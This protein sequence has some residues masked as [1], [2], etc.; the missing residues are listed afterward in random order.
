[1]DLVVQLVLSHGIHAHHA[2]GQVDRGPGRLQQEALSADGGINPFDLRLHRT[3]ETK[4]AD[5]WKQGE[6]FFH[7]DFSTMVRF[8]IRW[9]NGIS[10]RNIFPASPVSQR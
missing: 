2:V 7:G 5:D 8:G 4:R 10:P 6:G 9:V 1:M 3:V